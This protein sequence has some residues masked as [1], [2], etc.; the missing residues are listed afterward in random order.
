MRWKTVVMEKLPLLFKGDKVLW[1]AFLLLSIIP[2][3]A[4]L[5]VPSR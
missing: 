1:M 5:W 2:V 4:A 3:I